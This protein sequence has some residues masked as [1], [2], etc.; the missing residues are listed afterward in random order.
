MAEDNG[1]E[2][3]TKV[4]KLVDEKFDGNYQRAFNF[5]DTDTLTSEG[6]I[7]KRPDGKISKDELKRLLADAGVGNV[8]TRGAWADGIIRKLDTN[9]DR[10]ISWQ[11]FQVMVNRHPTGLRD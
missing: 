11:E 3:V 9:G 7:K 8:I 1:I 6:K 4:K 2:L 5:Y 10:C